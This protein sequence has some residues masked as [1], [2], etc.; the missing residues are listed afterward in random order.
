MKNE[1]HEGA[2]VLV[3][4]ATGLFGS[5]KLADVSVLVSIAVGLA[6]LFYICAKTYYL[7]KRSGNRHDGE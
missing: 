6:T 3:V 5:W 2:R 1:L 7:I 4:T